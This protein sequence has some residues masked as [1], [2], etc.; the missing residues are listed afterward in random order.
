[1]AFLI[2][3]A[4]FGVLSF[5]GATEHIFG[6]RITAAGKALLDKRFKVGGNV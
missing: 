2:S 4:F 3:P 1:L 5:K 6:V